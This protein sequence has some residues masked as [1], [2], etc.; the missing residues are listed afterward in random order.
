[1]LHLHLFF[2]ESYLCKDV[3]S[4]INACIAF[5]LPPDSPYLFQRIEQ[6]MYCNCVLH[7]TFSS[8]VRLFLFFFQFRWYWLRL[9]LS[10]KVLNHRR[11]CN[12]CALI[13]LC[14]S[15]TIHWLPRSL[16]VIIWHISAVYE[17]LWMEMNAYF[18]PCHTLN[19]VSFETSCSF[20]RQVV[21]ATTINIEKGKAQIERG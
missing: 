21:N 1:M 4:V 6:T 3:T 7:F 9:C 17:H 19:R 20:L 5:G 10:G 18:I 2:V 12:K 8:F 15:V 11:R 14:L 16:C 13:D